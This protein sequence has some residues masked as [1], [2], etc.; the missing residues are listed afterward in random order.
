MKKI[1]TISIIVLVLMACTKVK[2]KKYSLTVYNP[3]SFTIEVGS[4]H[5]V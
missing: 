4:G 1:I 3:E 2:D 5:F